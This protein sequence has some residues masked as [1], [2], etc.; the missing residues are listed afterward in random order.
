MDSSS[1]EETCLHLSSAALFGIGALLLKNSSFL[2]WS[3]GAVSCV[4]KRWLFPRGI[5]KVVNVALD[6]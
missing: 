3:R 6:T 2:N 1:I 5:S 4:T